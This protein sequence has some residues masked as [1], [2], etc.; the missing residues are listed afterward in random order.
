MM[1]NP[2]NGDLIVKNGRILIGNNIGQCLEQILVSNRGEY[3][4]HPLVGGEVVKML[5]GEVSR[6]WAN[7]AINMCN[8]MGVDV[9]HVSVNS[10]GVIKVER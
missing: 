2:D 10:N 8:A 5:H 9:K 3:K 4:E 6:F 1:I 7:R